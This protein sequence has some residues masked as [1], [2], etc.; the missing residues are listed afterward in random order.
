[1]DQYVVTFELSMLYFDMIELIQVMKDSKNEFIEPYIDYLQK[2][3]DDNPAII[4]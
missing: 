3:I 2:I 1:M 4:E